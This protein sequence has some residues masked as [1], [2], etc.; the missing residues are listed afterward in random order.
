MPDCNFKI[1]IN[2]TIM[3]KYRIECKFHESDLLFESF[4]Q[5]LLSMNGKRTA[6]AVKRSCDYVPGVPVISMDV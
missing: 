3:S 5:K 2:N 4:P 1:K 6:V